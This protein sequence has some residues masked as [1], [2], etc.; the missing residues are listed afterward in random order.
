MNDVWV[1]T[2]VRGNEISWSLA[3]DADRVAPL[4]RAGV[5]DMQDQLQAFIRADGEGPA[6][7]RTALG[8]VTISRARAYTLSMEMTSALSHRQRT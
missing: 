2:K 3:L 7:L 8:P 5:C 4:D 1:H 6:E